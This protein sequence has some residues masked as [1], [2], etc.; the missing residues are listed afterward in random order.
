MLPQIEANGL[1]HMTGFFPSVPAQV[2]FELLYAPVEG[3]W[4]LFGISVGPAQSGPA[5]PAPASAPPAA[6]PQAATPSAP[7]AAAPAQKPA[8]PKK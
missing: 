6:A 7:A 2:K 8:K 5:A 3:Q 1:M 4:K